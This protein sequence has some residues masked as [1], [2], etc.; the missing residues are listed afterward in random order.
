MVSKYGVILADVPWDYKVYSEKGTGR[1]AIAHYQ[2]MGFEQIAAM[3][4]AELAADD[5]ALFLWA[6]DPLLHKAFDL[7]ERWGF[8]FKTVGFY[9]AKT[10]KG[11]DMEALTED[12][13][14]TG[15]GYWS[16]ANP[17]QC[18]LATRGTPKRQSKSVRRLI[19]APRREHSR[20]PDEVYD[21]IE[22]LVDGPYLELFA[23]Q[24][25]P[26]WDAI[27]NQVGLFD[28]GHVETRN[29]PSTKQL[30]PTPIEAWIAQN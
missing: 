23:R 3:N 6:V 30:E 9:W 5:C 24:T 8:K 28:K 26:G 1:G 13:F 4:V 16:R 14:F 17:E 21:R 19:V 7:I 2:T 15:L 18:L 29:R 22:Q 25:R 10:N 20:K 11:A 27:G 12:D